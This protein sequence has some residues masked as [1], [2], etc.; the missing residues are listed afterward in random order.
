[1]QTLPKSEPR[2]ELVFSLIAKEEARQ[3]E[4]LE[5]IASENFTSKAVREA[6]GSVLTNKY[7]E[8]YPGK[9]YYGGCEFIDEI[10][11]LAID[12]AKQLFGQL[13]PTCSRT[14][15]PQPTWR[16]TMRCSSGAIPCWAWPLTKVA[17]SPTEA[18]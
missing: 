6:V 10:E 2:D 1:M 9:R 15:A 8:G 14:P 16:S 5:L 7:A 13:G 17:T 12:R 3:R 4:G 18:R 11:Q